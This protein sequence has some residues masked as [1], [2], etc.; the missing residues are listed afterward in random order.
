MGGCTQ[1]RLCT[2]A[3]HHNP[4]LIKFFYLLVYRKYQ[5]QKNNKHQ[6]MENQIQREEGRGAIPV[7]RLGEDRF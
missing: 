2:P 4:N 5:E 1:K 7:M 6:E 3:K